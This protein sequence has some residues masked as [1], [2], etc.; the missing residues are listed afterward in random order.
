M[1]QN[2]ELKR[3]YSRIF[4]YISHPSDTITLLTRTIENNEMTDTRTFRTIVIDRK[5]GRTKTFWGIHPKL[6]VKRS[7]EYL[8]SL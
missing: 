2:C 7:R 6:H 8:R 3:V 4:V 1:L 5:T